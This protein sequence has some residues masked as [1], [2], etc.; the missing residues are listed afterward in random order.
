MTAMIS[1]WMCAVSFSLLL[2]LLLLPQGISFTM[3]PTALYHLKEFVY[4]PLLNAQVKF[5]APVHITFIVLVESDSYQF[6]CL[7]NKLQIF[8]V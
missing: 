6:Y 3:A 4:L 7:W 8:N 5:I 1:L 2:G